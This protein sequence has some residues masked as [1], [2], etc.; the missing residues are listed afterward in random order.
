MATRYFKQ[1][2]LCCKKGG[3]IMK[4]ILEIFLVGVLVVSLLNWAGGAQYPVGNRI[5][6]IVKSFKSS[7]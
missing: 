1:Q 6:R 5:A 4:E 3:R 7:R 2:R